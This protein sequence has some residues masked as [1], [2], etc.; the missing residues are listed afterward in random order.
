M[1][2]LFSNPSFFQCFLFQIQVMLEAIV[3]SKTRLKLLIKLF[4]IEGSSGYIRAMEKEFGEST[5]AIRKE[6][7]RLE[8]AG[9]IVS[10][11]EGKKKVFRANPAHP[12][13]SDIR[14]IVRTTVG[15]DQIV[16]RIVSRVGDLEQAYITG[17]FATG[18]DSEILE[19]ALVG[20]NMDTDYINQLVR[21]AEK[22]IRRKIVYLSLTPEQM[23]HFFRDRPHL[24][25][26]QNDK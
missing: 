17:S 22:L 24:L 21:K 8:D 7:N 16:E 15:I 23:E 1:S 26:W 9:L 12:L 11:P 13:Y 19:L 4:F 25:I 20:R 10:E 2:Y 5:N 18:V 14:K 6:V 3:P